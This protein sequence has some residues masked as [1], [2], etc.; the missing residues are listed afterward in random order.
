M[1]T[2][3]SYLKYSPDRWGGVIPKVGGSRLLR[4][5][6]SLLESD[7]RFRYDVCEP[8]FGS[9]ELHFKQTGYN[10]LTF[11]VDKPLVT[12]RNGEVLEHTKYGTVHF[13]DRIRRDA[14]MV[15]LNGRLL[16]I[17]WIVVGDSFN[18]T[19]T[20]FLD[21]PIG[22]Q[23]LSPSMRQVVASLFSTLGA[24][25]EKNTVYNQNAGKRVGNYNLALCRDVTD[26]SDKIFLADLGFQDLWDDVELEYSLVIRTEF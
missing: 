25:M 2:L 26:R 8:F 16:F 20:N 12:G 1:F 10:W 13:T 15:L 19:K 24:A 4:V 11:C 23:Q 9:H 17:W 14:A 7:Y 6:E 21:A 3:I 5:F 22:P 18:L